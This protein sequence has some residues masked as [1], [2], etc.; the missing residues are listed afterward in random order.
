M[1]D[2]ILKGELHSS[3]EDFQRER[4]IVKSDISALV[5]E[6]A[7]GEN[8]FGLTEGWLQ[9]SLFVFAVTLGQL[10][11]D[12]TVLTDL[13]EARGIPV[14]YTRKSDISLMSNSHTT[15][16]LICAILFYIITPLSVGY[17]LLTGDY[18]TGSVGL[19][20]ATL[21]PILLLRLYETLE[22]F[23]DDNRDQKIASTIEETYAAEGQTAAIIGG[24]HL[25]GVEEA[26]DEELSVEVED[27]KEKFYSPSHLRR[28]SLPAFAGFGTLYLLYTVIVEIV[29][30][31]VQFI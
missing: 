6:G 1:T 3:L 4:E 5:L 2:V 19:L 18:F 12:K 30:R 16:V 22:P 9:I 17:G 7:E 21:L 10:Y 13:A 26:L 24:S 27:P 28:A 29:S 25:A 8:E 11:V 15:V 14:R 31:A 23:S 20:I